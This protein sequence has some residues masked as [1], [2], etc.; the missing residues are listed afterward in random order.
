MRLTLRTALIASLAAAGV[1]AQGCAPRPADCARAE[2]KCAGLVTDFGGV[3]EGLSEQA[4]LALED[5]RSAGLLDRT[6]YIETND[7]RDRGPN[8]STFVNQGYDIIVTLGPGIADKTAVAAKEHPGLRFIGVMQPEAAEPANPNLSVLMFHEEQGG[9]LAGAVAAMV[10]RR[11]RVAGVCESKFIDSVRRYCEG[12]KAGA[13][14]VSRDIAVD[15]RYRTGARDAL[16]HDSDWGRATAQEVMDAGAD[17]VFA[18]GEGT[19]D[20]ALVTASSRGV[21]VIGA[22]TDQYEN[23]AETRA[24]LVTSAIPRVRSGLLGVIQTI[25]NGQ[26]PAAPTWG[27]AGLAPFHEFEDRMS[28]VDLARL[29]AIEKDLKEGVI[30]VGVPFEV[31]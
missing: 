25:L 21:P 13:V 23:L 31:P 22:E 16:F 10:T 18:V 7:T 4:W 30:D 14:H 3:E 27:E 9:F 24:T 20:A 2:V 26:I 17:V 19:A 5:A 15:V 6:D 28:P 8:I 29:Q 1:G 11:G 12:F